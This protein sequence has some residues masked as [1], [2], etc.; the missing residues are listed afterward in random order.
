MRRRLRDS[1]ADMTHW[2]EFDHVIVNDDFEAALRRLAAVI[3]GRVRRHR[4]DAKAVRAAV[5]AVLEG[6][7]KA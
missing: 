1:L 3:A 2:K 7:G 6:A 4:T 5:G